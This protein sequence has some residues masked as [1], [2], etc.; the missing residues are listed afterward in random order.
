MCLIYKLK[1]LFNKEKNFFPPI[2]QKNGEKT[3][4][5]VA[6]SGGVDSSV[7]LAILKKKKYN[8]IGIY[9]KSYKPDGDISY[10]KKEGTDAKKIC[11]FLN[12]P[13]FVF[14]LQKEYKEKVFDYMINEYKKGNIPNPD[15]FCNKFIK[16][17]IFF[18]KALKELKIDYMATGHYAKHIINKDENLLMQAVDKNKDQTYFLSQIN[19]EILKSI[20]FPL[21]NFFKK[22]VREKAKE[23]KLFT[24]EKKDSQGLCFI[25]KKINIRTF[26]KKYLEKK[27][28]DILNLKNEIIGKHNGVYF[29]TIGQRY[30]FEIF[31]KFKKPDQEKYFVIKKDFKNNKLII[32]TR[33]NLKNN[34]N[35]CSEKIQITN[36]NLLKDIDLEKSKNLTGR[37]RHRGELI[38]IE[39]ILII[40]KNVIKVIFE[41]KQKSISSGQF[42][43]IYQKKICVGGGVII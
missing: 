3:K 16:F 33:E 17:G 13:F 32:G 24:A 31:S 26:L 34:Q 5:A 29:Y 1:N 36:L 21:G 35:S 30:G 6:I 22:E 37:I 15:I 9:F 38:N 23:F 25:Q 42:L 2:Y 40:N 12:V 20:I 43:V 39:K 7:A 4:I 18:E 11:H 28:G 8:V 41:K 14:D 10:C 27:D 19:K